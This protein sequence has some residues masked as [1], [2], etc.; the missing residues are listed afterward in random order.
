M[1]QSFTTEDGAL[2]NGSRKRRKVLVTGA[3]GNIGSY[4]AANS[5]DRYELRLMVRAIAGKEWTT[6][7]TAVVGFT[8]TASWEASSWLVRVAA[9]FARAA[10]FCFRG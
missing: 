4:F 3:A 6:T 7:G 2:A 5:C 9:P 8:P 1:A 10:N